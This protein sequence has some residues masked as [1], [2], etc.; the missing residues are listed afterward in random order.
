MLN[1]F[2]FIISGLSGTGKTT[3]A[4]SLISK[5]DN[6]DMSVS[7]TTRE[8]RVNE[9]NGIDYNFINKELFETMIKEEKFIEYEHIY[10]NLYGTSKDAII[11][12]LSNNKNILLDVN[13]EGFES[14]K[15][16]QSFN[17]VSL[18]ILPPSMDI[19]IDRLKKRG[20]SDDNIKRRMNSVKNEVFHSQKY[21]YIVI[22]DS[23]QEAIQS[24]QSIYLS[25]CVK[26]D[27]NENY[28]FALNLL[29][30]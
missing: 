27:K 9:I 8:K 24:V 29:K 2:C 6:I 10:N 30:Y 21:D 19:L 18:F 11:D 22:N 28:N 17:I 15:K 14:L 1:N 20:E 3:I 5:F 12:V 25:S 13:Y 23:L 4:R 7:F 16:N 26:Y